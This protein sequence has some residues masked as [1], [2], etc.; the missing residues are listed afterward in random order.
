V[1]DLGQDELGDH[2]AAVALAEDMRLIDY[3]QR[4]PGEGFRVLPQGQRALLRGHDQYLAVFDVR[5]GL[6]G[7]LGVLGTAEEFPDSI[8][9]EDVGSVPTDLPD[10]GV[11]RSEVQHPP[12]V[13]RLGDRQLRHR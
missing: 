9:A 8:P 12:R 11:G 6:A 2:P 13:Q 5:Q 7:K 4:Q 10:E 3:A 1:Q